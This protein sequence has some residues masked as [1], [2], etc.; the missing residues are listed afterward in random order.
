MKMRKRKRKMPKVGTERRMT[1][2]ALATPRAG[3]IDPSKPTAP[4]M[5]APMTG[6]PRKRKG[7]GYRQRMDAMT[8]L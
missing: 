4:R 6:K 8:E 5:A 1:K 7:G 3:G 2:A